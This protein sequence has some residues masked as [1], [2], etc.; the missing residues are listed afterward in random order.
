MRL[1]GSKGS[2][3]SPSWGP[4]ASSVDHASRSLDHPRSILISPSAAWETSRSI[5]AG[6]TGAVLPQHTQRALAACASEVS[7]DSA[8]KDLDFLMRHAHALRP[9]TALGWVALAAA[10]TFGFS[11][12]AVVM[13]GTLMLS[14]GGLA[15]LGFILALGGSAIAAALGLMAVCLAL[16][17]LVAGLLS[18]ASA[19]AYVA[20]ATAQGTLRL[21]GGVAAPGA[22]KARGAAVQAALAVGRKELPEEGRPARDAAAPPHQAEHS[23]DDDKFSFQWDGK[24]EAGAETTSYALPGIA[25]QAAS[26]VPSNHVVLAPPQPS[27]PVAM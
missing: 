10:G 19:G 17:A 26:P 14:I 15:A 9:R 11:A 23:P 1:A 13:A 8:P 18:T 22:A 2:Q 25:R 24:N 20:L 4:P 6:V 27:K 21:L 7:D 5:V 12:L 16:A 3:N